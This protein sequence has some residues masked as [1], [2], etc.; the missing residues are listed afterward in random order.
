MSLASLPHKIPFNLGGLIRPGE[1]RAHNFTGVLPKRLPFTLSAIMPELEIP[2]GS[3]GWELIC[4]AHNDFQTELLRTSDFTALTFSKELSAY[5]AGSFSL[6]LDHPLFQQT[7][8]NGS[9]VEDLFDYE[10][11]WDICFDGKLVFQV[12]GTAVVDSQL[13]DSELRTATVSGSGTGKVLEW[14]SVYP[15]GFPDNIITKLETL[16]DSFSGD[17]IDKTIWKGTAIQPGIT[18]TSESAFEE[19]GKDIDALQQE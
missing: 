9:S 11:L 12:L 14:A 6:N 16:K 18:L 10:N 5:G 2:Y 7:L 8:N 19:A 1:V 3:L 4:R 15:T 13:S 17:A